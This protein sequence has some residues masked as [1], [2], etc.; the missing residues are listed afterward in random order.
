MGLRVSSVANYGSQL[1]MAPE[2]QVDVVTSAAAITHQLYP[3][4]PSFQSVEAVYGHGCCARQFIERQGLH[5]AARHVWL[6]S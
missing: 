4:G 5:S 6:G 2:R 1:V 3:T